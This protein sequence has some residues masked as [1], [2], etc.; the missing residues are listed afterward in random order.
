MGRQVEPDN[1]QHFWDHRHIHLYSRSSYCCS[2]CGLLSNNADWEITERSSGS[3]RSWGFVLTSS[4]CGSKSE[5]TMMSN[6]VEGT[7]FFVAFEPSLVYFLFSMVCP[8]ANKTVFSWALKITLVTVKICYLMFALN[9]SIEIND[10]IDTFL[11]EWGSE[12]TRLLSSF[13]KKQ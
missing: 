4:K 10:C 6:P 13:L 1:S 12:K 9:M 7:F 3:G 11:N 2:H 5:S 8:V